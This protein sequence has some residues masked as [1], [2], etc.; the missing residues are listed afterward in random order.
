[1]NLLTAVLLIALFVAYLPALGLFHLMIF[2][3][4]RHLPMRE[5]IPHSLYL[6]G[7]RRLRDQYKGFYPRSV[8]Y[9]LTLSSSVV[10]FILAIVI[11][12]LRV[13]AYVT[14]R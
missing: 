14:G 13:W 11:V 9:E 5:K 8:L 2:R 7:W 1:M 6:G 10:F 4:N 3:V 12:V